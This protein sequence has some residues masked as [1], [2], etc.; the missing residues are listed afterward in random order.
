[1]VLVPG[2]ALT[3]QV[4]ARFVA[5][6]G[7]RVALLHLALSAG[8]RYDEWRR[9]LD[10]VANVVVSSRSGIFAALEL[11]GLIIADNDQE[12]TYKQDSIGTYHHVDT[13]STVGRDTK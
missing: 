4:V 11:P 10:G 2:I 9:V 8:E 13:A 5:R 1:M 7:E 12:P 3:A 6:F